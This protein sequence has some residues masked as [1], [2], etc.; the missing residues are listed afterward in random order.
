[1]GLPIVPIRNQSK[2]GI[3]TDSSPFDLPPEAYSFGVN[4]RFH[5]G[6]LT[7][8][9][10]FRRVDTTGLLDPRHVSVSRVSGTFEEI[11][12]GYKSGRVHKWISGTE[13]D[14]S[15]PGYSDAS[16]EA[17]WS[18]ISVANVFYIN[19]EDRVPWCYTPTS[20]QFSALPNWDDTH[21]ARLLRSCGGTL[22][23]LNVTKG[24][25]SYPQMVKWADFP[26]SGTVPAN[27]NPTITETN[28]GE[29]TL[30]AMSGEIVDAAP[31]GQNLVIYGNN[32]AWL[33]QPDG[34][35]FV[36]SFRR[37]FSDQGAI[38][39]NCSV[40]VD[41]KHFVFGTTDI[42]VHDGV[43]KRSIAYGR[44]RDFIFSTMNISKAR[45]FFVY[46][47]QNL[48]EVSFCYVSGD[49]L[50]TFTDGSGCNRMAV[51]NYVEDTWSFVDT[52]SVFSATTSNVDTLL[53]Y[54][55]ATNVSY[56][57][58]GGSYLDQED[59][60]KR[61]PVYVGETTSVLTRGL[62]AYDLVGQGSVVSFPVDAVASRAAY[63][64]RDGIDLDELG[65][66]LRGYKVVT[67]IYPQATLGTNSSPLQFSFGGN[68]Y[69]NQPTIFDDY[70]SYDGN[71]NYKLDYRSGGRFLSLRM[72][73]DDFQEFTLTGFDLDFEVTGWR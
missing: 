18:S 31:L 4:V 33:M 59:S 21:R 69:F 8:S 13:S 23:A 42:W 35:D 65:A 32:E 64:E 54:A 10:V 37:L 14:I 27:W 46:H 67:S 45:Q 71:E 24:S 55:A 7:R 50:A 44:V 63:V 26:E 25:M 62:Y 16:S 5:A 66:E 34:S 36:F 40:E 52:P 57:T 41:G 51:Y 56:N 39:A 9:P 73:H 43:S 58:V 47:N 20:S 22:V 49:K 60:L 19:R 38:N 48:N 70:Q 30:S 61:L 2:Y 68:T 6:K 72:L 17:T 15:I 1:M 11:I 3:I 53:S 12:I 29:S 28:A